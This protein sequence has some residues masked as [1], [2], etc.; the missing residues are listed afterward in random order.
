[1]IRESSATAEQQAVELPS[2]PRH[3]LSG[4][5]EAL[6]RRLR[7]T[8]AVVDAA[9]RTLGVTSCTGGEGVSTVAANLAISASRGGCRVLL[10]DA[11]TAN[12]SV[13]RTFHVPPRPGLA[14]M[15][16]GEAELEECV[17]A[18]AIEA[19]LVLPAGPRGD[20]DA[21]AFDWSH[22]AEIIAHLK[23]EYELVVF[24]LPAADELS[25]CPVVASLLDGVLL[26]VEAERTGGE[27]ALRVKRQLELAGAK[28]LGV[29]LN[30]G[31]V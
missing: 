7:F 31:R 30:K 24:D 12:P 6:F 3:R 27:A 19:L 16:V 23:Q 8:R 11:N 5:Y 26:V 9:P 28:L 13:A 15:L 22:L 10:V 1:M 14:D 21:S 18:T 20:H 29:V 25:P 2:A 4:H 17:H